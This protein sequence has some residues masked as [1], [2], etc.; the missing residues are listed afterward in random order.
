MLAASGKMT[1]EAVVKKLFPWLREDGSPLFPTGFFDL[2]KFFEHRRVAIGCVTEV[3]L[4]Q[5][6]YLV[7]I[8]SPVF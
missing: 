3:E 6:R 5:P 7:V 2:I 4:S 8:V 1:G